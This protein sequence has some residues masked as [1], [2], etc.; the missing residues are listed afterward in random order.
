[1]Y[2]NLY[3]LSKNQNDATLR[4]IPAKRDHVNSPLVRCYIKLAFQLKLHIILA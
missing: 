2:R 4:R 1:M 3:Q